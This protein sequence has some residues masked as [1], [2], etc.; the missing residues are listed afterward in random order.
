MNAQHTTHEQALQIII[1]AVRENNLAGR[2]SFDGLDSS[3]IG[4]YNRY[5]MFGKNDEAF[6]DPETWSSI[7]D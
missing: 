5:L 7:V 3:E 1:S 4:A 6:P 2:Y